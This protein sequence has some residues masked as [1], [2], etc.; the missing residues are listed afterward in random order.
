M[1][2]DDKFGHAMIETFLDEDGLEYLRDRDGD[3][4]I[5]FGYD[6]EIQ[7]HPRFLLAVA[8]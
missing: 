7:G 4:F 1:G 2:F 5:Q 3:F 8:G 6:E